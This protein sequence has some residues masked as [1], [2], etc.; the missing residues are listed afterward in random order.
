MT[1][2]PRNK[3][4]LVVSRHTEELRAIDVNIGGLSVEGVMDK[5]SQI[6]GLRRD[7]WERLA[8]PLQSDHIMIMESAN[9]STDKMVGL[10][11]DL[12][13]SIGGFKFYVQAQVVQ[14]VPYELLIGRP[15]I[16]LTQL[17]AKNSDD[18]SSVVTL[19]DPNMNAVISVPTR[20]RTKRPNPS[21][22]NVGF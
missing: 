15:F 16:T 2:L 14:D 20:A 10:I 6:I 3:E 21:E 5:G 11:Q 17:V 19:I 18:G 12:E 7:I 1:S 13:I 4:G 8:I 9:K 22:A